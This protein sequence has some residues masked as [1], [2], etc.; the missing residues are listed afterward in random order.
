MSLTKATRKLLAAVTAL[1]LKS[2]RT[3]LKAYARQRSAAS[4]AMLA[5]ERLATYATLEYE[6][7]VAEENQ[8][9]VR[10]TMEADTLGAKL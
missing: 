8:A 7:A 3:A 10:Y 9:I 6:G 1:H 5:A 2:L 4:T